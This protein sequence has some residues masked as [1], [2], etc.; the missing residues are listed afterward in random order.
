MEEH[1][2]KGSADKFLEH[3][4]LLTDEALLN[5]SWIDTLVDRKVDKDLAS[6]YVTT[7]DSLGVMFHV[8]MTSHWKLLLISPLKTGSLILK[9]PGTLI[10]RTSNAVPA[11]LKTLWHGL[12]TLIQSQFGVRLSA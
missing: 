1:C 11:T 3:P 4:W 6:R 12:V 5:Q 9:L 8:F 2:G 10:P 7:A